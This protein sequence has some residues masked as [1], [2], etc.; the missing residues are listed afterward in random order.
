MGGCWEGEGGLIEVDSYRKIQVLGGGG[1]GGGGMHG[2]K[3]ITCRE[4]R[5]NPPEIL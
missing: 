3:L 4:S 1:G 5:G 2:I